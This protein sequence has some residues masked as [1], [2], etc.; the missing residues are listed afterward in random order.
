MKT[1]ARAVS[2]GLIVLG[3]LLIVVGLIAGVVVSLRGGNGGGWMMGGQGDF[4]RAPMMAYGGGSPLM[5]VALGGGMFVF[6]LL[7]VAVGQ[8]LYFLLDI[9]IRD[10]R[11]PAPPAS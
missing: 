4:D 8:I 5:G 7:V 11:P 9:A 2:Y 1:F 10:Q 6:G 3:V